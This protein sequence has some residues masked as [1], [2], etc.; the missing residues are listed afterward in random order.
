MVRK[1][2]GKATETYESMRRKVSHFRG[3]RTCLQGQRLCYPLI[4]S[5]V[6]IASHRE[7]VS[8]IDP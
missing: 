7:N 5:T 4:G 8:R 6:V 3:T 1:H 2:N